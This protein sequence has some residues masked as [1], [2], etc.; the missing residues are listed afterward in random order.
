MDEIL[1]ELGRCIGVALEEE[2]SEIIQ[3]AYI[4]APRNGRFRLVIQTNDGHKFDILAI[5]D[6][7]CRPKPVTDD[8]RMA[9]LRA[10][11]KKKGWDIPEDFQLDGG[12]ERGSQ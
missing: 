10:L 6:G 2:P 9:E 12:W 8:E 11:A 3:A 1:R 5:E 4:E 7:L